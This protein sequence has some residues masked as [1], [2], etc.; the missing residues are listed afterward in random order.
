MFEFH[1]DK[2][3]YFNY[4]YLTAKN[5]I[6]PYVQEQKALP[7]HAKVLEI[8]CAEAGVLKAFW[9]AGHDCV[10]IEL[11]EYRIELAKQ[12]MPEA[13]ASGRLNLIARNIYDI[14]PEQELQFKFDLII[15][16]DV[17]EH[18]PDQERF[19]GFL[20]RF[21]NPGGRVFFAFPPWYMPFGGHQ[22]ICRN[23]ILSK[24]PWFHLLPWSI[25]QVILKMGGETPE[26]VQDL[27]EIWD[28]GISL[29]RFERI[30]AQHGYQILRRRIYLLN[31]I[32]QLKFGWKTREQSSLLSNIPCLRDFVSTAA[33]Y[34]VS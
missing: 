2:E 16:K 6:L 23:K 9:E 28:T 3:R 27:K 30:L 29:Q 17:I 11:Q 7:S 19:M 33:Y 13:I 34:L 15:L 18:I 1:Q 10:G 22:Q 24:L 12:F 25:Y 8:G 4:Q 32:Y 14:D 20:R 21:L 26:R 31:P 5:H